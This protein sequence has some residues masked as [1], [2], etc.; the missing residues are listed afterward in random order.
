M[1]GSKPPIGQ[2]LISKKLKIHETSMASP[3]N[4]QPA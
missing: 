4:I 1:Q 3:L 2:S